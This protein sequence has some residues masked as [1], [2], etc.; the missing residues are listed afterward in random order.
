MGDKGW[1]LVLWGMI[2]FVP[3]VL[4]YEAAKALL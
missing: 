1:T 4:I 2:A 3:A